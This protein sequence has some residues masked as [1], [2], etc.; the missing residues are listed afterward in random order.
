MA[1]IKNSLRKI[2]AALGGTSS[3]S[4]TITGLLDD[5]STVASSGGGGGLPIIV[6]TATE[7]SG[8]YTT[9]K[10]YAEARSVVDSGGLC[11]FKIESYGSNQYYLASNAISTTPAS[12]G[13]VYST[14]NSF[15]GSKIMINRTEFNFSSDGTFT[16]TDTT[17]FVQT[18]TP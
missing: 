6:V 5:I 11:V 3:K 4:K 16:K 1:S 14:A 8:E 7:N 17:Y 2:Y 15:S 12:I 9:D 10:T 13:Y 18:T